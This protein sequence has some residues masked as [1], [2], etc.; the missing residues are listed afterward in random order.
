MAELSDDA[1]TF[2]VRAER[3]MRRGAGEGRCGQPLPRA[4]AE[5]AGNLHPALR[6]DH[7]T[8]M[9][10]VR[11][12]DARGAVVQG[13]VP[14]PVVVRLGETEG[15]FMSD[16]DHGRDADDAHSDDAP[17]TDV[18]SDEVREEAASAESHAEGG[19]DEVTPESGGDVGTAETIAGTAEQGDA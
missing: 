14:V 15:T 7:P 9:F 4:D 1:R 10:R 11:P 5:S 18:M 3:M 13:V 8:H 19:G 17:P 6:P 2:A 12:Y 16:I